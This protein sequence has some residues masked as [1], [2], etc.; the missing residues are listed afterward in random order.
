MLRAFYTRG[1]V[2]MFRSERNSISDTVFSE[3]IT[4]LSIRNRNAQDDCMLDV[5]FC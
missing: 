2:A 3:I 5:M 1:L 4:S